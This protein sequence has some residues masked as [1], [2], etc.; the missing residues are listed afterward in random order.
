[1]GAPASSSARWIKFKLFGSP[2]LSLICERVRSAPVPIPLQSEWLQSPK[3]KISLFLPSYGCAVGELSET[4]RIVVD[5]LWS[6]P[7]D[8][9]RNIGVVP[10]M[11]RD[12]RE[13]CCVFTYDAETVV[14]FCT[15]NNLECIIR[16]H[17]CVQGISPPLLSVLPALLCTVFPRIL[18]L[19]VLLHTIFCW[20]H[21]FSNTHKHHSVPLS[22]CVSVSPSLGLSLPL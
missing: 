3:K 6:D 18:T 12:S 19:T 7:A 10:N 20:I 15:N 14:R 1:M 4:Q 5:A 13:N 22:A 2:W 8:H 17:E 21:V 9:D 16:A 11:K